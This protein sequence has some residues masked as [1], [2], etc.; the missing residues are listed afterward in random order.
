MGGWVAGW[1][2]GWIMDG[3]RMDGCMNGRKAEKKGTCG[4]KTR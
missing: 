3:F 2:G 1:M 4:N